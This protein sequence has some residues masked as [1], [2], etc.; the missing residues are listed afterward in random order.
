VWKSGSTTLEFEEPALIERDE[1]V[2]TGPKIVRY[3]PDASFTRKHKSAGAR[4]CHR[5]RLFTTEQQA[6]TLGG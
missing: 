6:L 4:P 1:K 2:D 3:S 5:S